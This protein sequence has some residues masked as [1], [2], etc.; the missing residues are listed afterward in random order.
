MLQSLR[1]TVSVSFHCKGYWPLLSNFSACHGFVSPAVKPESRDASPQLQQQLCEVDR[2]ETLPILALTHEIRSAD[3]VQDLY[4]RELKNYKPTPPKAS[5]ASGNVHAFS[6]PKPPP[7]P[8]EIEIASDLKAYE[9]Q[10][11][12]VEGQTAE[13]EEEVDRVTELFEGTMRQIEEEDREDS[14]H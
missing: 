10:T 6:I 9:A 3:L 12:E 4:L 1:A 11:V 2:F 14:H 8:E 5:D 7:S 13:G